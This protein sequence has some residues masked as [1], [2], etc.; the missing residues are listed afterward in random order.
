MEAC[1][2]SNKISDF[3]PLTSIGQL[4]KTP[5]GAK[6][7]KDEPT[8]GNLVDYVWEEKNNPG[9]VDEGTQPVEAEEDTFPGFSHLGG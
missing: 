9:L 5:K 3:T 1:Y 6:E 8:Y 2:P 4:I 7:V